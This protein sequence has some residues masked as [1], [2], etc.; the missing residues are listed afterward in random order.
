MC[1]NFDAGEVRAFSLVSFLGCTLT[2]FFSQPVPRWMDDGGDSGCKVHRP[3]SRVDTAKVRGRLL[4]CTIKLMNCS[5][6]NR[7]DSRYSGCTGHHTTW[8]RQSES[9]PQ[10]AYADIAPAQP[11]NNITVNWTH[12]STILQTTEPTIPSFATSIRVRMTPAILPPTSSSTRQLPPPPPPAP[13]RSNARKNTHAFRWVFGA[14]N[15]EEKQDTV[16]HE[17]WKYGYVLSAR[18]LHILVCSSLSLLS[19]THADN[20]RRFL[21]YF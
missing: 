13:L 16:E 17:P 12:P 15:N 3:S 1:W 5:Y 9:R 19:F 2:P 11:S 20:A 7:S 6:F 8:T 21:Q 18:Q 10:V 14:A 4:F